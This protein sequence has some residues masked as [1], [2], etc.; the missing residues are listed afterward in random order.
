[1]P[2]FTFSGI[3]SKLMGLALL[4]FSCIC[5]LTGLALTFPIFVF[6]KNGHLV[7]QSRLFMEHGEM[8]AVQYRIQTC[9][10]AQQ[11]E[12]VYPEHCKM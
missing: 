6:Q 3:T 12:Q 4:N 2:C 10:V 7:A 8:C 1:M 9:S 11:E 5:I